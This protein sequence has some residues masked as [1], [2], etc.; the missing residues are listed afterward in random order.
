MEVEVEVEVDLETEVDALDTLSTQDLK[1]RGGNAC[2]RLRS[3][4]VATGATQRFSESHEPRRVR[5]RKQPSRPVCA[6]TAAGAPAP[7]ATKH[8]AVARYLFY[9][10]TALRLNSRH[11]TSAMA[12]TC[13]VA[14]E[15]W[16]NMCALDQHLRRI[17]MVLGLTNQLVPRATDFG[18]GSDCEVEDIE[19]SKE[20][21]KEV[22]A[23]ADVW[24]M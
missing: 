13:Y 3:R 16:Q 1:A 5:D 15:S 12:L 21:E 9:H 19:H 8:K 17:D 23:A 7:A 4:P 14:D 24:A 20:S 22:V 11:G 10:C 6:F 2:R 18:V